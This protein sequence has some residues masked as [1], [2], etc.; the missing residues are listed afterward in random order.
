MWL[1]GLAGAFLAGAAQATTFYTLA[2]PIS[3]DAS[4][5]GNPASNGL[6]LGTVNPVALPLSDSIDLGVGSFDFTTIDLDVFVVDVTL[7]AGS[8][9]VDEI[10]M[11]AL[12]FLPGPV[13]APPVGAGTLTGPG[14]E[15]LG[16][17]PNPPGDPLGAPPVSFSAVAF[18]GLFNFGDDLLEAGETSVALFITYDPG[19]VV[20][21]GGANFMI[22]AGTDFTVQGTAVPEPST[23]LLV[24][25][26]LLGLAARSWRRQ[27]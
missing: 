13:L 27:A 17:T 20:L 8:A 4:W 18:R 5:T 9:S 24:A 25:F 6:V 11:Y 3:I 16:R 15:P 22:S 26:G 7:S 2:D 12:A 21:D 23:A 1:L 14:Q 19:T 10:G